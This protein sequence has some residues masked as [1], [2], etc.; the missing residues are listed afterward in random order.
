M[1]GETPGV[2]HASR[3][4]RG[5]SLLTFGRVLSLGVNFATQVLIARYL[6]T[7]A[8]GAWAYALSLVTLGETISTFGLDRGASRFLAMYDEQRDYRRLTG[9]LL[10]VAGTILSLGLTIVLLVVGLQGWLTDHVIGDAATVSVLVILIL[11]SPLQAAD[12][13]LSGVLATFASAKAIF[14]RRY[15]MTPGLRL[16]VVLLLVLREQEVRFLAWGYVLTGAAG[17]IAYCLILWQV[18]E[19]RGVRKE[20]RLRRATIPFKQILGFTL[21][22]LTTDLVYVSM[23]TTDALL[24]QHYYGTDEVA[25]LRVIQPLANL[26][27]V[28]YSSFTLLF[29]PVA[30]R[31]LARGDRAG[32]ADLYWRTAT[33]VAVFSFPMF[34]LTVTM[35]KPVTI[36]FYEQRYAGSAVFL[37]LLSAGQYFNAALGFNGLTLRVFGFLRYTIAINLVAVVVN[38]ALNLVLTPRMGALGA[39]IATAATLVLHN[40]L[41]QWGLRHGTGISVFDWRYARVYLII[42]VVGAVLGAVALLFDPQFMVSV[43]IAAVA[44]LLVL[45]LN[46]ERLAIGETFPEVL[47]I[48]VVKHL[49]GRKR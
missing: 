8:Y 10:L 35:A 1:S 13:L 2:S 26:N 29:T 23:V 28:V 6:S 20:L 43:A 45:Y 39:A 47:R 15:V 41:K 18:L 46:R 12:N 22:L 21:P 17:I 38:V 25:A 9:T 27:L 34:A 24:L 30:S 19:R 14:F 37:A 4:I 36:A 7:T 11:L 48:P 16:T 49:V 32:V 3:Q 44:S 42:L 40:I 5:S 31:L 33:W